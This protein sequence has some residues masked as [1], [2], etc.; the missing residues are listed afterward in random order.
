MQ[1]NVFALKGRSLFHQLF[2]NKDI[3]LVLYQYSTHF[4]YSSCNY[5]Y[6][7]IM[8]TSLCMSCYHCMV[9]KRLY[10]MYRLY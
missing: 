4:H 3:L 10:I 2:L 9:P 1:K 6:E 8:L 7:H 5:L